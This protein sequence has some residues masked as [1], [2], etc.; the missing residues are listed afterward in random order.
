MENYINI[1][2]R[3]L[4]SINGNEVIVYAYLHGFL[5]NGKEILMTQEK[6]ADNLNMPLRTFKGVLKRL[7]DKGFV[8][9]TIK[10][11][12]AR[13]ALS[14]E[15]APSAKVAPAECQSCTEQG[16]ELAPTECQSCTT[17]SAES[18]PL[19]IY[20]KEDNKVNNKSENKRENKVE[21]PRMVSVEEL[22]ELLRDELSNDLEKVNLYSN[23]L[24]LT[25]SQVLE[26]LKLFQDKL[27]LDNITLKQPD[28]YRKH[29][30][31][32]LAKNAKQMFG[33]SNNNN[34]CHQ[35]QYSAEFMANLVADLTSGK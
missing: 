13:I 9:V 24:G 26:A 1:P 8:S 12:S 34:N 7:Q 2:L 33:N 6:M 27:K 30:N 16:A 21:S 4:E 32:W 31:N 15:L 14:A 3:W 19:P 10:G 22:Y 35:P 11:G 29:F 5:S 18:A 20:K 28:D 17:P 23:T 25:Q